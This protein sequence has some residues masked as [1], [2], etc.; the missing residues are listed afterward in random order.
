MKL[1]R[2]HENRAWATDADDPYAIYYSV[3]GDI[4]DWTTSGDDGAGYLNL[5]VLM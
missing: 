5:Q 3:L 2:I 4:E 1:V